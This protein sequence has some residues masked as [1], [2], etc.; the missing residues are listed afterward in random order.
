MKNMVAHK[1][2]P[3]NKKIVELQKEYYTTTI[4]S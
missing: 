1:T 2:I 4:Q 3:A